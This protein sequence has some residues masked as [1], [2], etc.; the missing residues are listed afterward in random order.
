[1]LVLVRVFVAVVMA[2]ALTC[3]GERIVA[4]APVPSGPR[5]AVVAT[6]QLCPFGRR[7]SRRRCRRIARYV[8][9]VALAHFFDALWAWDNPPSPGFR[10]WECVAG[11]ETRPPHYGTTGSHYSS[12]FGMLNQAIRDRADNPASAARILAGVASPGEERR[13]AWREDLAFGPAAWGVLTRAKCA[14]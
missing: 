4:L 10:S 7:L 5:V 1:M 14:T 13:A 6:H 2:C 8:E 12:A 3:C 11:A 9:L